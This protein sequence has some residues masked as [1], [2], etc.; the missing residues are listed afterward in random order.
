MSNH[1][2]FIYGLNKYYKFLAGSSVFTS[3]S[4]NSSLTVMKYSFTAEEDATITKL[5]FRYTSR[6]GI[7]PTYKISL[8]D[9]DGDGIGTI[10]G[11]GSPASATFTPPNSTAWYNTWQNIT[12]D[13]LYT[14]Y[15]GERLMIF[16]EWDSGTIDTSNYS[17]FSYG[18]NA[19]GLISQCFPL[20][21]SSKNSGNGITTAYPIFS[22][23]SSTKTYGSPLLNI[24][25]IAQSAS[26]SRIGVKFNIPSGVF[27]TFKVSGFYVQFSGIDATGDTFKM[28]VYDDS[29]TLQEQSFDS[30]IKGSSTNRGIWRYLF[31]PSNQVTLNTNTDY[32]L[33]STFVSGSYMSIPTYLFN[34]SQDRLAISRTDLRSATY[35]S[36]TWTTT[37]TSL[38][39]IYP[40]I[41]DLA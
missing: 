31:L 1:T 17:Q 9:F 41:T 4:M 10:L 6:T 29:S 11:G 21:N 33:A 38:P 36:S 22:Y 19:I 34:S 26:I 16:I 8:R 25:T 28:G 3:Y 40:I 30:D 2:N 32:Y 23:Q 27:S 15:K 37:N 18:Q 39:F 13:N 7:P 5:G 14:C 12:L 35:S 20:F 24:S